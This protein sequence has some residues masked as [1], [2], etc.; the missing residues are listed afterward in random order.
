MLS[1]FD[2]LGGRFGIDVEAGILD[3]VV[4]GLVG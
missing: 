1:D 4:I 3:T 2:F